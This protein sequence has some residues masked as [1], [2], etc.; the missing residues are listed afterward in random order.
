MLRAPNSFSPYLK[1]QNALFFSPK[2]GAYMATPVDT[3]IQTLLQTAGAHIPQPAPRRA[4]SAAWSAYQAFLAGGV[5]ALGACVSALIVHKPAAFSQAF[6]GSMISGFGSGGAGLAIGKLFRDIIGNESSR[7][8]RLFAG[9]ASLGIATF[10]VWKVA[11]PTLDISHAAVS[12]TGAL[13]GGSLAALGS[14]TRGAAVASS[15][16]TL[17]AGC[18]M[19]YFTAD[20]C[21]RLFPE[22]G[23][24]EC[25]LYAL[26]GGTQAFWIFVN[27]EKFD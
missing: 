10:T 15:L 13:I 7:L 27:K 17:G 23:K 21:D 8:T 16:A 9:A 12:A 3:E 20:Q 5:G 14:A 1:C 4:E 6:F 11:F 19:A 24:K 2:Q 18:V 22:I 25:F 26:A